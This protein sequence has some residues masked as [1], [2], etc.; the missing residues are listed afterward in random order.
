[1]KIYFKFTV[2]DYFLPTE[3]GDDVLNADRTRNQL[4]GVN[5]EVETCEYNKNRECYAKA[6][7]VNN[8]NAVSPTDTNCATFNRR[9]DVNF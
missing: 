8:S 2:K 5:C 7:E 9:H 1:M 4:K 3:K 6:I